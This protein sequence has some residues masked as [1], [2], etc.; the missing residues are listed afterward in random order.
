MA[1]KEHVAPTEVS[2]ESSGAVRPEEVF[3]PS[4]CISPGLIGVQI[5]HYKSE[6]LLTV[7]TGNDKCLDPNI[8]LAKDGKVRAQGCCHGCGYERDRG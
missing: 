4:R 1:S 2:L 7:T 6:V 3:M 5:E 8:K